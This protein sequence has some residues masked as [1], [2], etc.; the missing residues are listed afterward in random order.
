MILTIL[1]A[2]ASDVLESVLP[3]LG[4]VIPI[5]AALV[6]KA[7]ARFGVKVSVAL[8]L[9][10]IVAGVS[11][12]T[13]P[14][15]EVTARLVLDRLLAVFGQAQLIYVTLTAL[16]RQTTEKRSMNEL[17]AFSPEKGLG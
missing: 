5:V 16:V 7:Q 8:V 15:D 10:V 12:A 13:E 6:T 3:Y 2:S 9:T 11:L 14:W 4:V 17:D 1:A